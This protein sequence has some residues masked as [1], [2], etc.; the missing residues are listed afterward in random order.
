MRR[1]SNEGLPPFFGMPGL[2]YRRVNYDRYKNTYFFVFGQKKIVLQPMR[3]HD[4]EVEPREDQ[5]LMLRCFT[6]KVKKLVI[7]FALVAR[8]DLQ[9]LEAE[10]L[11]IKIQ[12]LLDDFADLTP[13]KLP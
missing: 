1:H 10:F 11:T 12:A 5:I 13:A 3:I 2:Y 7:I 8:I 4:F 9:Q 6:S